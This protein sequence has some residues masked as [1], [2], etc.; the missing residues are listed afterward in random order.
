MKKID[1][2]VLNRTRGQWD[3]SQQMMLLHHLPLGFLKTFICVFLKEKKETDT[4]WQYK[5][6][7]SLSTIQVSRGHTLN[8]AHP[9]PHKA[10]TK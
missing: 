2:T 10:A 9:T 6:P 7:G 1:L 5:G 8:L 3:F 4:T